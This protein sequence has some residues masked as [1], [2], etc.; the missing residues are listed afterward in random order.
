MAFFNEVKCGRCDRKYSSIRSRCPYCGARK[1]RDG[2]DSPSGKDSQNKR[3]QGIIGVIVLIIIILAVIILVSTSLKN[4]EPEGT[5]VPES[6]GG[7]VSVD[8]GNSAPPSEE[9]T[10]E[11]PPTFVPTEPPATPAPV[12]NSITLNRADFTLFRIGE[13]FQ[14]TATLSPAGTAAEVIWISEDDN[15]VT[16]DQDGLVT[17][18]DR[19]DT[20]VSATAGGITEECIVRVRADAPKKTT[21]DNSGSVNSGAASGISLNKTDVTIH[22]SRQES[23]KLTVNGTESTPVYSSNSSCVSV[24][25]DGTVKAVS[26]GMATITVTVPESSGSTVTMECIVRVID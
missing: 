16:V 23:F 3:L 18:V 8:G 1:N 4:R 25:A 6:P 7:V 12:V 22:S 9:P 17:A 14:I 20:I 21:T 10:D 5:D 24:D 13:T 15:V 19:G 2:K 26:N 11:P